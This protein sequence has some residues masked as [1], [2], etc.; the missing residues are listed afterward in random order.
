[1]GASSRRSKTKEANIST[2]ALASL[3]FSLN[4]RVEFMRG[5]LTFEFNV[6]IVLL[7]TIP[8][9][10]D[11]RNRAHGPKSRHAL[12]VDVAHLLN[13]P[14]YIKTAVIKYRHGTV[15]IKARME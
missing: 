7:A 12:K 3:R 15:S 5:A 2:C 9:N 10:R 8:P 1:M 13:A 11:R 14:P 4:R 6:A